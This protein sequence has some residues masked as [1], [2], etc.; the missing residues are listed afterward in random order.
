MQKSLLLS[1][2]LSLSLVFSACAARQ[3]QLAVQTPVALNTQNQ[4]SPTGHPS[5][6]QITG[7]DP[8]FPWRVADPALMTQPDGSIWVAGTGDLLRFK[9]LGALVQGEKPERLEL[10][11]FQHVGKQIVPLHDEELPW[12]LQF[13]PRGTGQVL[14]GG[15]MSPRPGQLHA[16]WP[17]DN[18][19]RR[20]KQASYDTSRRGWVFAEKPLFGTPDHDNPLG[21]AYG[22]QLYSEK[23]Q[24][25]LFYEAISQEVNSETGQP[26]GDSGHYATEL[27]V[28]PLNAQ[29]QAGPERR[30]LGRSDLPL[31]ASRRVFGG[32]LLEGPRPTRYLVQGKTVHVVFFSTGDYPT[33]NYTVRAAYSTQGVLGP[34]RVVQDDQGRAA[35]LTEKLQNDARLYGVGRAFPFEYQGQ[36][37]I[38][39]H[40]AH[41]LPGVDH[42]VWPKEEPIRHLFIAP[43]SMGF[44]PDQRFWITVKS[45]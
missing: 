39:F 37:W 28:R 14:L 12:D 33:K 23:G 42:T 2:V 11:L 40:G 36:P 16:R 15:V 10:R 6:R 41:D 43:L 17:Q 30:I 1:H 4:A 32:F 19:S 20:I 13:Y 38:I 45:R 5:W 3:P 25:Y 18:L 26:D 24:T 35:N 29:G 7:Q 34:Y 44:H 27:F 9:N 21:H 31:D 22:H 8:S